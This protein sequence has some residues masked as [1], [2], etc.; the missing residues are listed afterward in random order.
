MK[1]DKLKFDQKS[2]NFSGAV[3]SSVAL[4]QEG[5]NLLCLSKLPLGMDACPVCLYVA[6]RL[7]VELSRVY[8]T[9]C[10]MTPEDG[11]QLPE[12]DRRY[13]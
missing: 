13:R 1:L 4:Q 2:I 3:D 10:M 6:L 11:H 9:P 8:P 5:C 7:T 12:K